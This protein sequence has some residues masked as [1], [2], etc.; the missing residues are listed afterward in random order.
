MQ[1]LL[2][3]LY[4]TITQWRQQGGSARPGVQALGAHQ[5]TFCSRLKRVLSRNLDQRMLKVRIFL[6]KKTKNRL[7][8]GGPASEPPFSSGGSSPDPRVVSPAYHY[9][10]VQFVSSAKCVFSAFASSALL[11]LFFTSNSGAFVDG[12]RKNILAPGRRIP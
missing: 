1:S 5:H 12:G 7:S 10:F 9:N 3:Q 8:V 6:E 4:C 11:H 2:G